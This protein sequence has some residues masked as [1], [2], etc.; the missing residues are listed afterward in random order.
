MAEA[1]NN[2]KKLASENYVEQRFDEEVRSKEFTPINGNGE[3]MLPV[4]KVQNVQQ[5]MKLTAY[6]LDGTYT[7]EL[8]GHFYV[9]NQDGTFTK[10]G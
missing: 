4:R 7:T 5:Y 1:G 3:F 6:S 9:K 8:D 10:V 2:N